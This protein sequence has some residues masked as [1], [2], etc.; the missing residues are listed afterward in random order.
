MVLDQY[1]A[2]V[3]QEAFLADTIKKF[4]EQHMEVKARLQELMGEA[5][6]AIYAGRAVFTYRRINR[7]NASALTK[8]YPAISQVY[9]KLV[10]K[11]EIDAELLKLAQPEIY[12]EFQVRQFVRVR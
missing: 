5:E 9:T 6:E 4:A 8:A 12:R 2:L 10:E 7:L 3:E 11:P 1:A